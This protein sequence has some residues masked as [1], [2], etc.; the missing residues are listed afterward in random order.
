MATS[1]S[2]T[3]GSD[4]DCGGRSRV[5]WIAPFTEGGSRASLSLRKPGFGLSSSSAA[6]PPR[7]GAEVGPGEALGAVRAI[8]E[9][10]DSGRDGDRSDR[11]VGECEDSGGPVG[12]IL[13]RS[14]LEEAEDGDVRRCA[15]FWTATAAGGAVEERG[16]ADGE[17]SGVG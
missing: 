10:R 3:D 12:S 6:A 14:G 11:V 1:E 13:S 16:G 5:A 8:I 7:S 9:R 2:V 4:R 17:V 15:L